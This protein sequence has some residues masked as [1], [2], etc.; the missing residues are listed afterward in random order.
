M[1]GEGVGVKGVR[2]GVM[3]GGEGF[4]MFY[5]SWFQAD[6]HSAV[7]HSKPAVHCMIT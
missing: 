5:I 4:K 7:F 6:R 2:V 1:R 3:G